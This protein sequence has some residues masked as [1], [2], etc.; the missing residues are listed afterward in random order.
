[1]F[2]FEGGIA[3][4]NFASLRQNGDKFFFGGFNKDYHLSQRQHYQAK[5]RYILFLRRVHRA[6]NFQNL[7]PQFVS[8]ANSQR[9]AQVFR[10]T[11]L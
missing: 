7:I 1:M 3:F 11:G 2:L 4:C 5:S 8:E 9:Q 10:S 6:L